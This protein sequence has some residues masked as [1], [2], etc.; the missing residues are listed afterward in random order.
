MRLFQQTNN[1]RR[2]RP[3]SIEKLQFIGSN[4]WQ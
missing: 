4:I 1:V 2:K 3:A